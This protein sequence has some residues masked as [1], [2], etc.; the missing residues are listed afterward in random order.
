MEVCCP[1]LSS[2]A[3]I[4]ISGAYCPA[5]PDCICKVRC[6]FYGLV[7]LHH[8]SLATILRSCPVTS[9]NPGVHCPVVSAKWVKESSRVEKLTNRPT[10]E[11]TSK[12]TTVRSSKTV[13]RMPVALCPISSYPVLHYCITWYGLTGKNVQ[14]D[15]DPCSVTDLSK[16]PA[17]KCT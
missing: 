10:I 14:C 4:R 15:S 8:D 2:F 17:L 12:Q 9:R 13:S 1:V 6:R 16:Y 7:R 5:F 3:S 11:P